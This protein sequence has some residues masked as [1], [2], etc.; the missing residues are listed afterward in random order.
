MSSPP[1][2]PCSPPHTHTQFLPFFSLPVLK[3]LQI[4]W[5]QGLGASSASGGS[6]LHR[7][8]WSFIPSVVMPS[9]I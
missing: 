3:G 7:S 2:S 1:C 4:P 6:Q 5:G 8:S 9:D